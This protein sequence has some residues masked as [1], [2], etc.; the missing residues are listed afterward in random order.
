VLPSRSYAALPALPGCV[1]NWVVNWAVSCVNE[2]SAQT[3]R[4]ATDSFRCCRP[5]RPGMAADTVSRATLDEQLFDHQRNAPIRSKSRRQPA[6]RALGARGQHRDG[7]GSTAARQH[8]SSM[9]AGVPEIYP[10]Q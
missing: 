8:G 3:L 9:L 1:L 2:L 7:G 5:A 6:R 4:A 10:E